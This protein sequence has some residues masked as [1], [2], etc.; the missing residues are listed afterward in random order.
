MAKEKGL[1]LEQLKK[2]IYL[3][4]DEAVAVLKCYYPIGILREQ[5][6]Q[7]KLKVNSQKI[8]EARYYRSESV[9]KLYETLRYV[10]GWRPVYSD[11]LPE[12]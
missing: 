1:T 6:R 12:R 11:Y 4:E 3:T 9:I 8:G 7:G 10:K 5:L 2:K